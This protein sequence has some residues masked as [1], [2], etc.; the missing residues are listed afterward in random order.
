M[1]RLISFIFFTAS[2]NCVSLAQVRRA[3]DTNKLTNDTLVRKHHV[4]SVVLLPPSKEWQRKGAITDLLAQSGKKI[5]ECVSFSGG[6]V[7]TS[8]TTFLYFGDKYPDQWLTIVISEKDRKKFKIVPEV[9]FVNKELCITG[10]VYNNK[11]NPEMRITNPKQM[12]IVF[13]YPTDTIK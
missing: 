11:G 5:T 1:K 10:I 2:L 13:T 8:G 7:D 9:A 6:K 4:I 12:E 3:S